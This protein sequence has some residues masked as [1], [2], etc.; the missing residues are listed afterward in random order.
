MVSNQSLGFQVLLIPTATGYFL[1]PHL[2][3]IV[4]CLQRVSFSK[5]DCS[6]S[7]YESLGVGTKNINQHLVASKITFV[8]ILKPLRRHLRK[9]RQLMFV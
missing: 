8:T 5:S 6:S 9:I 4:A 2:A 7:K 1:L 3:F